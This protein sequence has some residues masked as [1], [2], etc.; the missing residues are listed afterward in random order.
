MPSVWR[1]P[2]GRREDER[3][4]VGPGRATV[5][6][7][8]VEHTA[9]ETARKLAQKEEESVGRSHEEMQRRPPFLGGPRHLQVGRKLLRQ[10]PGMGP[11][12]NGGRTRPGRDRARNDA[13]A[14]R[15]RLSYIGRHI[16]G[17]GVRDA[18]GE[19]DVA[20][21][22]R[23]ILLGQYPGWVCIRAGGDG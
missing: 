19:R 17:D 20:P 22:A 9:T 12:H 5:E 13:T 10:Q 21:S 8:L 11:V 6:I 18:D 14:L 3:W 16:V 23:P 7:V 2:G 1:E 4:L 15:K